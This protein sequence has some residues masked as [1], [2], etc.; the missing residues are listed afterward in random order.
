MVP[1]SEEVV[2]TYKIYVGL[3]AKP[4]GKVTKGATTRLPQRV[5]SAGYSSSSF[6]LPPRSMEAAYGRSWE[7]TQKAP[8]KAKPKAHLKVKQEPIEITEWDDQSMVEITSEEEL[9]Q[10]P[11]LRTS[12]RMP[13]RT[14]TQ[15]PAARPRPS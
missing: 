8:F 9:V 13:G 15:A 11:V 2:T 14:G 7:D 1:I 5:S 3:C 6:S 12:G 10:E 4:G